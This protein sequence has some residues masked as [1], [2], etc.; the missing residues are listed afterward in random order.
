VI[1]GASATCPAAL[2]AKIPAGS[3]LVDETTIDP[4]ASDTANNWHSKVLDPELEYTVIVSGTITEPTQTTK[5]PAV[6]T[7]DALYCYD[8]GATD[9]DCGSSGGSPLR[10]PALEFNAGPTGRTTAYDGI[11]TLAD[12]KGQVPIQSDHEYDAG[13]TFKLVPNASDDYRIYANPVSG[14]YYCAKCGGALHVKI[15][16]PPISKHGTVKLTF[17]QR[18]LPR[19]HTADLQRSTTSGN[20]TLRLTEEPDDKGDYLIARVV[21]KG[22]FTILHTDDFETGDDVGVILGVIDGS[23]VIQ[24]GKGEILHLKVEVVTSTDPDC[25]EGARGLVNVFEPVAGSRASPAVVTH[26]CPDHKHAFKRFKSGGTVRVKIVRHKPPT[27][28]RL[29]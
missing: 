18:G 29:L 13:F 23:Y 10:R 22:G 28:A 17:L 8:S 11:D 14:L 7:R 5:G 6:R 24:P 15:Y 4:R 16:A 1:A 9:S 20:G 3:H 27:Q 2:A 26:L 21:P 25:T 12:N 19:S